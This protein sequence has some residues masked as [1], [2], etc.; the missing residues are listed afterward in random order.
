MPK[1]PDDRSDTSLD[2]VLAALRRDAA[3]ARALEA[4]RVDR[5]LAGDLG[6][7]EAA[8]LF[9]ELEAAGLSDVV[10]AS[11]EPPPELDALVAHARSS[12][13]RRSARPAEREPWW[14]WLLQPPR[15]QLLAAGFA[16]LL[17]AI[18]VAYY[19][20]SG[21]GRVVPP[22]SFSARVGDALLRSGDA[23]PAAPIVKQRSLIELTIHQ[24]GPDG[25]D[26]PASQRPRAHVFGGA[27]GHLAPLSG[28]FE[29]SPQGHARLR[30]RADALLPDH[31]GLADLVVVLAPADVTPEE[32]L[33]AVQQGRAVVEDEGWRM[34][35]VRLTVVAEE[36]RAPVPG[37]RGAWIMT[38]CS[39]VGSGERC[40][41]CEPTR[42]TAWIAGSERSSVSATVDGESRPVSTTRVGGGHRV[43][44]EVLP[45]ASAPSKLVLRQ[46][47]GGAVA[48]YAL[49]L[50]CIPEAPAVE[51]ARQLLKE[52][53][54]DALDTLA[55][56]AA[57]ALADRPVDLAALQSVVARRYVR[58]GDY[59]AAMAHLRD[60]ARANHE[61]GSV[62]QAAFD[63]FAMSWVG[64]NKT[65]QLAQVGAALDGLDLSSPLL[66][67]ERIAAAS[68]RAM[69]AR[70]SGD[71]A[72]ALAEGRAG[73]A[74]ARRLGLE[75][76]RT[77]R[78]LRQVHALVLTG[79]G[80]ASSAARILEQVVQRTTAPCERA[81]TQLNLGWALINAG[82]PAAAVLEEAIGT[83][84]AT[85]P[86]QRTELARALVDLISEK[87]R[88]GGDPVALR[89]LLAKAEGALAAPARLD[90]AY[91]DLARGHLAEAAAEWESAEAAWAGL[92]RRAR[93]MDDAGLGW[94]AAFGRARV[95]LARGDREAA[96]QHAVSAERALAE[97]AGGA[98][99][100]D[101]RVGS[102]A[103]RSETTWLL[104]DLLAGSGRAA[105]AL[106]VG[107]EAARRPFTQVP[108]ASGRSA[109]VL[110]AASR[111][112]A[113]RTELDAA[114]E[115]AW[116][117][118]S[119]RARHEHDAV[120][121]ELRAKLREAVSDHARS[122]GPPA[123]LSPIP[124]DTVL[125]VLVPGVAGGGW[126]LGATSDRVVAL[127]LP[128][129]LTP[130]SAPAR[131]G[132]ELLAPLRDLGGSAT[133]LALLPL[134]AWRRLDVHALGWEG[135]PVAARFA[136]TYVMEVGAPDLTASGPGRGALIVAD[137]SGNL[138]GARR[139]ARQVGERLRRGGG[140]VTV[141]AQLD[142][143][144][145]AVRA[146]LKD[147]SLFVYAGHATWRGGEGFDSSLELAD[148]ELLVSEIVS[149][150]AAPRVVVLGG[151]ETSR[152]A[153]LPDAGGI[154]LAQAFVLAGSRAV[155]ATERPVPD[156]L[157]AAA[158]ASYVEHPAAQTDPAVAYR[159]TLAGLVARFP[160]RDWAT[161]RMWT[162]I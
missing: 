15:R 21:P 78:D 24:D 73:L 148:G 102:L 28:T 141:L 17:V 66:G 114:L 67:R 162:S 57:D 89:R 154:G 54:F 22:H 42:L 58:A 2:T 147:A 117:A 143:G 86:D 137:P 79:V 99:W 45:P 95:A 121:A 56:R 30:A 12:L 84:E 11:S 74:A 90:A 119:P 40:Q 105:E 35:D 46:A 70:F 23:S 31:T 68:Y 144:P 97:A 20:A 109:D 65:G 134:G 38:G 49:M 52:R 44:L 157:A 124:A 43:E 51:E 112:R 146:G 36:G 103:R 120:V 138:P 71:L 107:R 96:L 59:P 63:V 139:E 14:R 122:L 27:P 39:D 18:P 75:D 149:L 158:T 83:L 37:R 87:A 160:E 61:A 29:W 110:E 6:D 152:G 10:R 33:E 13:A 127:P 25:P 85:C 81:A 131:L 133:R 92:E 150:D 69:V 125:L 19:L 93:V 142:A 106:V 153:K 60:S 72:L 130:R 77:G 140:K 94:E 108:R 91:L 4:E 159:D 9:T 80:D 118:G 64:G 1:P 123:V 145:A 156:D 8:A 5:Y 101:G 48:S 98:A 7:D 136:T 76:S 104:L 88:N 113:R 126:A 115:L 135:A 116:Q 128:P 47:S 53:Q 82:R 26:E 50:S 34:F 129:D 132:A 151:C 16:V 111:L 161:F 32:V 100:A 41:V 3:E 155:L 62:R 55:S